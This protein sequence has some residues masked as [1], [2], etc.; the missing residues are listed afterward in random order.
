MSQG[1]MP[2]KRKPERSPMNMCA[3]P[4]KSALPSEYLPKAR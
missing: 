4:A 3:E 1:G 2:V